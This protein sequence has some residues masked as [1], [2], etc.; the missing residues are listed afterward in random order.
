MGF[1]NRNWNLKNGA[2]DQIVEAHKVFDDYSNREYKVLGVVQ[3]AGNSTENKKEKT[4]SEFHLYDP[5]ELKVV[6]EAPSSKTQQFKITAD[7]LNSILKECDLLTSIEEDG[8]STDTKDIF[9]LN[10]RTIL[11]KLINHQ[12]QTNS[13]Q[14][15][16]ELKKS[17][18]YQALLKFVCKESSIEMKGDI[19]L[20]D[21]LEYKCFAIRKYA[22]E[23]QQSLA[24]QRD[25]N[26][27]LIKTKIYVNFEVN[28]EKNMTGVKLKSAVNFKNFEE[29]KEI[30]L[31]HS[32]DVFVSG[33]NKS[34]EK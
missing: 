17:D 14:F 2:W 19:M 15:L 26:A 27:S 34:T 21:W 28:G 30:K 8:S 22:C 4:Q 16:Q 11:M 18:F 33:D 9:K 25:V 20:L 10:Q 6:N 24:R 23:N 7:V 13:E 1:V 5:N 3:T 29:R 12:L 32:N 31:V